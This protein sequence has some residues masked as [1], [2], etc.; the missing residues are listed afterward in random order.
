MNLATGQLTTVREFV[1]A[2]AREL[3][4]NSDQLRFGALPDLAEEMEHAPVPIDRLRDAVGWVPEVTIPEGV[5]R[6]VE[7]LGKKERAAT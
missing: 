3:H 5:R 6:T 4:L 1:E 7:V 2:A